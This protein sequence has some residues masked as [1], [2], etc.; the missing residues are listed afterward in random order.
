[1]KFAVNGTK[2]ESGIIYTTDMFE[3]KKPH[4]TST[5]KDNTQLYTTI[6]VDPDAPYP[7]NPHYK[8]FIHLLVVNSTDIKV[9]YH[10]PNPPSDSPPHRYQVFLYLQPKYIQLEKMESGPN[11][12][13]DKF[14]SKWN[15][16]LV[17]QFEF[18]CK[19]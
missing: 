11:F 15:L 9:E 14:V 13:L 3:K 19:K 4:I 10:P 17:D 16:K 7:S 6:I 1:M 5:K 2:I 8:Y 12:D 18:L